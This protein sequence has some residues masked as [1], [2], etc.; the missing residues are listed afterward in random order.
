MTRRKH[1][2]HEYAADR[3]KERFGRIGFRN[4]QQNR[5]RPPFGK[6]SIDFSITL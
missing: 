5:S 6:V 3:L 2:I 1:I 4:K